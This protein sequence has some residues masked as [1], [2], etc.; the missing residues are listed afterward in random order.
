MKI[1]ECI[2]YIFL[3]IL[4]VYDIKYRKIPIWLVT[5]YGIFTAFIF[6]FRY[7]NKDI[8]LISG[9]VVS[10]PGMLLLLCSFLCKERIGVGDGV[11]LALT[12]IGQNHTFC[13]YA[14]F[15]IMITSILA[16]LFWVVRDCF[17]KKRNNRRIP[18][19]P[20]ILVGTLLAEVV[21]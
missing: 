7:T 4:S 12:E 5:T 2:S 18:F 20:V 8:N 10:L 3:M 19:I 21:V 15:F 9:V 17:M 16:A 14:L 6:G 1:I 13:I 11:V